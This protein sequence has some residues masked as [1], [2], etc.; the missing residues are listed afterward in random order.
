MR[1]LVVVVPL[2]EPAVVVEEWLVEN[3]R[4]VV[5]IS[6]IEHNLCENMV[7]PVTGCGGHVFVLSL[8]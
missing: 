1:Q 5:I 3:I 7:L 6:A 2:W 8:L 4:P